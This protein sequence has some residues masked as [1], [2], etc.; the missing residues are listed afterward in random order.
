M[1]GSGLKI[2]AASLLT[3]AS[4]L[5][6]GCC[7]RT[8]R[9]R[10]RDAP[11]RHSGVCSRTIF[12]EDLTVFKICTTARVSTAGPSDAEARRCCER[13]LDGPNQLD[14]AHIRV[15]SLDK[16]ISGG[17]RKRLN[18]ALNSSG[19]RCSRDLPTSGSATRCKSS[20][21]SPKLLLGDWCRGDS[22]TIVGRLQD[23]RQTLDARY[24]R[25]PS[26]TATPW[27]RSSISEAPPTARANRST[28]A[29]AAGTSTRSSFSRSSKRRP[30]TSGG[31]RRNSGRSPP[32]SGASFI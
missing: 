19:T 15:G 12:F 10:R 25:V 28:P 31:F 29:P 30:S 5:L 4:A 2:D 18:I 22:L 16:T 11:A 7:R 9:R 1:G 32:S 6:G 3:G 26:T 13:M 17:Q 27:T 20:R 23:V 14:V 21:C 24:R 8:R